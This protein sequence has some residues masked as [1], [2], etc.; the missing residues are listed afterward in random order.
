MSDNNHETDEKILARIAL[1]KENREHPKPKVRK[2]LYR[3]D[4]VERLEVKARR[5]EMDRN[6]R[7][8]NAG[9]RC[10]ANDLNGATYLAWRLEKGL[11]NVM[12]IET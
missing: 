2:K 12:G 10:V 9:V 6:K 5:F 1:N 11:S 3:V 7:I 4:R 8:E